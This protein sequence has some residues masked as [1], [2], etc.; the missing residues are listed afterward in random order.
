MQA[1]GGTHAAE[2]DVRQVVPSSAVAQGGILRAVPAQDETLRA[3]PVQDEIRAAEPYALRALVET[4]S[5]ASLMEPVATL[6]SSSARDATLGAM[7]PS[8]SRCV[9]IRCGQ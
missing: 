9:V 6:S 1:L 4:R 8:L 2:Q 5:A 7:E 3:F